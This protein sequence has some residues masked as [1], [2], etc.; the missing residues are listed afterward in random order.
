MFLKTLALMI[1]LQQAAIPDVASFRAEMTER[2]LHGQ[3]LGPDY[4]RTLRGMPPADRVEAII[5]LR[6]AGLLT[7]QPWSITDL[8]SPAPHQTEVGK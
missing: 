3:M 7:G 4:R 1:P 8:L 5:F 6:R 2:L